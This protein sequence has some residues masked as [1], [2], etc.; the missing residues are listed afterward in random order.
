M[1][2]CA[3]GAGNDTGHHAAGKRA[4][5]LHNWVVFR[6]RNPTLTLWQAWSAANPPDSGPDLLARR[7][8]SGHG[9]PCS[10]IEG[11]VSATDGGP[12]RKVGAILT[13]SASYM[14]NN[15]AYFP[16]YFITSEYVEQLS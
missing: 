12:D 9:R 7:A 14:T 3:I 6:T 10:P 15:Y 11:F 13:T 1:P 2:S 4:L 16:T 5:K 8:D